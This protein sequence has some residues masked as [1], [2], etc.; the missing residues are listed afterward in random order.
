[1]AGVLRGRIYTNSGHIEI[2]GP[3]LGG[4]PFAQVVT[5]APPAV[6]TAEGALVVGALVSSAPLANGLELEQTLGH[7]V[8]TSH[9]TFPHDGVMRYDVVDWGGVVPRASAV[10]AASD[11]HE[12]FY[13]FG[14]KFDAVD[15]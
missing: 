9:L 13:G 4:R 1:E 14:E 11:D 5:L 6:E 12:H 3:D 2:A 10:A 7:A 8:I 15:Q